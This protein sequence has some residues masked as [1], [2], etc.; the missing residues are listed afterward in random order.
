MKVR[1]VKAVKRK[2]I[3]ARMA[4]RKEIMKAMAAMARSPRR[5]D[6]HCYAHSMTSAV[7]YV[8]DS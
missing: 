4:M 1:M 3:R 6:A 8:T 7:N 2:A 5:K